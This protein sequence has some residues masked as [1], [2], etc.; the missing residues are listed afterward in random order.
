MQQTRL[1]WAATCAGLVANL[2]GYQTNQQL[3]RRGLLHLLEAQLEGLSGHL[4]IPKQSI[5]LALHLHKLLLPTP[6]HSPHI[7]LVM[8]TSPT[9]LS[10]ISMD[11]QTRRQVVSPMLTIQTPLVLFK[12]R[13]GSFVYEKWDMAFTILL[14]CMEKMTCVFYVGKDPDIL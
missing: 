8:P 4:H 6:I 9:T 12:I 10:D 14:I 2:G 13:Q 11:P 1:K 3:A 5:H 7:P